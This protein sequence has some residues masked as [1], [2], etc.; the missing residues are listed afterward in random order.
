MPVSY[1]LGQ[2]S[3]VARRSWL[4]RYCD[5]LGVASL[6]DLESRCTRAL[7]RA[8]A[9]TGNPSKLP[10]RLAPV[11]DRF[12][13]S[14][15]IEA[16][17]SGWASEVEG[18]G[19][20]PSLFDEAG[21]RFVRGGHEG[22]IYYNERLGQFVIRIRQPCGARDRNRLRFTFAHEVAHRLFFVSE[23]NQWVRAVVRVSEE[24][25]EE[26][27][28]QASW[29]L[30]RVEEKLCNRIA[31]RVLIPDTLLA[32]VWPVDRWFAE[33]K[34]FADELLHNAAVFGVSPITLLVRLKD[35]SRPVRETGH[36]AVWACARYGERGLSPWPTARIITGF[37]PERVGDTSVPWY[38]GLDLHSRWP[39]VADLVRGQIT[40]SR[41][42]G[43]FALT[44]S[45]R[46]GTAIQWEGW[47]R[48]MPS[49]RNQA[50]TALL[51]WGR[52]R[53]AGHNGVPRVG[54][55]TNN[56]TGEA[57]D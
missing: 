51:V 43:H 27:R 40:S 32:A 47:W 33:E 54:R 37:G 36:F 26:F 5:A 21:C 1:S 28:T 49:A 7:L 46:S 11:L 30:G 6:K 41:L 29:Y 25:P 4:R 24:L 45:Q 44:V 12:Q 15:H 17:V 23:R 50:E 3:E 31:R 35:V 14:R 13:I 55:S 53:V 38:P 52:L 57:G 16:I 20:P 19:V 56:S 10:I 9:E 34:R 42:E 2:D 8:I 18:F 22:E 48:A 39:L